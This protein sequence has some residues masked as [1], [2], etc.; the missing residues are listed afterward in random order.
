M[1]RN[2]WSLVRFII[3]AFPELNI[4]TRQAKK[5]TALGPIMVATAANRLLGWRVEIIDENNYRGPRDSQGLPD[6]LTLQKEK[7]ASVVGFYCG[8]S[9]TMERVW[10]LAEF[11]HQ[12]KV[13]TIAGGWHAHY[14]PGE[15]LKHNIDLVIHGDGEMVIQQILNALKKE[16]SLR[17]IPGISFWEKGKVRTNLPERLEIPDL[18]NLPYPDFGLLSYAKVKIYPIGRIRGCSMNCEFCSVK[19]RPRWAT[20]NYFFKV[21]EWLAKTRKARHFF[22][23]DDRLEEDLKGTY[24]FFR[25]ISEKYGNRLVFTVQIRLE[26]AKNIELLEVMKK[27]GVRTAAIGYESPIDEDLKAMRKGYSSSHMLEWTKVLSR[28]FW[29]HAMFMVGYPTKSK[30][31]LIG[32]QET[33]KRFRRFIRKASPDS[34]QVL[35]P[36]PLVGTGLRQRLGREGRIF[37][38]ELVS[39]SKYDGNHVCFQPD[40]MS[41]QE[42]QEIPMRLMSRFYKALSGIRIALRTIVFPIDCVFRGFRLWHRGW[43]RDV[44]KY[45]GHLLIQ[46]WQK[47]QKGN[48]FV[49]KLEE[50]QLRKSLAD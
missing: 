10:G 22:I 36:V 25:M 46:R 20:A 49:E 39:W 31:N 3:P 19:G 8:L 50:Y 33:I 6:H 21:V 24:E 12:K 40:N 34:V 15:T 17:D 35:H 1:S 41:L 45:G 29:I 44:I 48:R 7:P 2:G 37:P 5:T 4:F 13:V 27:A 43:Y 11:Y 32:V 47:R 28:Y 42:F 23:V 9:S 26:A 30:K 18:N 16:E 14:C 38:L